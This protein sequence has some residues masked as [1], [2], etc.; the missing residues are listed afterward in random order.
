[1]A[2]ARIVANRQADNPAKLA[3]FHCRLL[4]LDQVMDMGWITTPVAPHTVRSRNLAA[5][6]A[7]ICATPRAQ[8]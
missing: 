6:T 2:V 7:S 4:D 3:A 5:S 1:M 8:F